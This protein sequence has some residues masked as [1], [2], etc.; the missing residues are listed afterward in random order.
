MLPRKKFCGEDGLYEW[1]CKR[2]EFQGKSKLNSIWSWADVQCTKDWK[3][4]QLK[5]W[6]K[7][8]KRI[9]NANENVFQPLKKKKNRKKYSPTYSIQTNIY[10]K[11]ENL[12]TIHFT[13]ESKFNFLNLTADSFFD[14][15]ATDLSQKVSISSKWD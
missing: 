14:A 12:L 9:T 3:K 13:D 15:K 7:V 1:Y 2:Q 8:I 4:S 6:S 10:L 5:S 11:V